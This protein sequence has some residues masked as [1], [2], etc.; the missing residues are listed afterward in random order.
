[1]RISEHS[2][3]DVTILDLL[4]PV[5]GDGSHQL[6]IPQIQAL[7]DEGHRRFVLNLEELTWI[8]SSGLGLLI[9]ARRLVDEAGGEL[10]ICNMNQRI[11]DIFEITALSTVWQIYPDVDAA[12]A[13]L[14]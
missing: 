3:D 6:F 8:N 14:S 10:V 9:G 7:L 1:M 12:V 5:S 11:T 2:T 13:A 4:T